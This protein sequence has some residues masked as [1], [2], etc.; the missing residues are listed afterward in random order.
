MWA[1]SHKKIVMNAKLHHLLNGVLPT[2]QHCTRERRSLVLELRVVKRI[3]RTHHLR[4]NHY[5]H[6]DNLFLLPL[7]KTLLFPS[8]KS[9]ELVLE[10]YDHQMEYF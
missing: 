8:R 9:V 7:L 3:Y 2:I 4:S 5:A 10:A 1:E 6:D